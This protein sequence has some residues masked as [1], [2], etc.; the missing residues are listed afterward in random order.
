VKY[1]AAIIWKQ[2]RLQRGTE[3]YDIEADRA[4]TRN[5][6]ADHPDV[7]ARMRAHYEAWWA[8]RE[9]E[10]SQPVPVVMGAPGHDPSILTSVDWWEVDCDNINFVS[11]G[12]GGPRGGPW[13]VD[14]QTAGTYRVELRRWPFHTNMAIGSVGP[15]QTITGRALTQPVKQMPAY[16][17]VLAAD[18]KEQS[19]AV[20][21]ES[22][23]GTLQVTLTRGR[24]VLQ[25]WFRG[26]DG[27]DLC[28]A[29]YA[30]FTRV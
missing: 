29:Y 14:V 5:V 21:P 30:Q 2:W 22:V 8:E 17:A 1:D 9:P 25:G 10:F 3:L 23:G 27:A 28:G 26:Q 16:S 11:N 7:M 12:T 18:G 4:Q 15:R 6:A 24:H 20:T 19:V 13:H